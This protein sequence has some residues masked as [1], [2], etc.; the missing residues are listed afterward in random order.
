VSTV[1]EAGRKPRPADPAQRLR[2][3]HLDV[4][5]PLAAAVANAVAFALVRPDVGDLQAALARQ[6][7]AA[8]GVGLTYWF[9]WFGGGTTPGNYSVLT[10][11]L[12]NLI[13]GAVLV[14]VL[15]T[16]AIPLLAHR[17]FADTRYQLAGTW[18]ATVTSGLNIWSGRVPFALGGAVALACLI[19]VRARQPLLI[20]PGAVVTSLCSPVTG[21]FLGFGLLAAFVAER[22]LRKHLALAGMACGITLV[23]VA[24]VFG[25]PGT[26]PYALIDGVLGAATAL[27][28]LAAQPAPGVRV[29]LWLTAIAGPVLAL[30]PNGLGSNFG[31]FPWI[32]LPAVVIAT[33]NSRKLV[34]GLAILPALGFCVGVT[35]RDL[36]RATEP[37]ASVAYYQPL[38][39]TLQRLPDLQN[40][41]V[42]VVQNP[43]VHTA[44]VALVDTV[45]LAG[46]YETQ[47]ARDLNGLLN[48]PKLTALRYE[49]WLQNNSVAWVAFDRRADSDSA[50]YHLIRS[51]K[52][53][54]LHEVH[55]DSRWIL[56]RYTGAEPIVAA[57][58]R[59][60]SMTQADMIVDAPCA[61]TFPVRVRYSRYLSAATTGGDTATIVDDGYGW[62]QVTTPV[63]GQYV[64][65]GSFG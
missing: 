25:N 65:H 23:V 16:I 38:I 52:L 53:G 14:G 11:Y 64:F 41:R 2:L 33:A 63:A 15:A 7:A 56:Y 29:A 21:V 60:V 32:C 55:Q 12:S 40:Y 61:C 31:R 20:V 17:V 49:I 50:E 42:E 43:N 62:T 19:G 5:W 4:L 47:A 46:G 24:I 36:V 51:G 10:P 30:I 3:P 45:A 22:E 54:Y 18:I 57:P 59:L 6:S 13:G 26:Q 37:E 27:A 28:M 9:T 44:A 39:H 48:D 58:E 1:V 8:H 35:A 34:A